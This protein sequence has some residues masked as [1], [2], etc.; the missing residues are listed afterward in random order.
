LT[1]IVTK[2]CYT[3]GD[4]AYEA[5]WIRQA[6]PA[7][8]TILMAPDWM[9]VSD[10][11]IA[12]ARQIAGSS[13]SV[14]IAD[15]YGAGRR[16]SSQDEAAALSG[17]LKADA[18]EVRARIAGAVKAIGADQ[19]LGAAVGFCF[20]GMNVL[21]LARSGAD[22]GLFVSIHGDLVSQLPAAKG[23]IK[24]TIMVLH[25]AADPI[26]PKA[27][28]DAFEAEMEA[29]E[30]IWSLT[31]F[32]KAVHSFTDPQ[33]NLPNVAQYDPFAANWSLSALDSAL[34]GTLFS[35]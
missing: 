2:S 7:C 31:V 9:G 18:H 33:A 17:P 23:V 30:A 28:R 22:L 25:G 6:E 21:E 14:F 16:P 32:G 20:G 3:I 34:R 12:M 35:A 26:A 29:A 24:G 11:A 19:Q 10:G 13:F 8:P 27:Q 15:M 5:A 1:S 4:N